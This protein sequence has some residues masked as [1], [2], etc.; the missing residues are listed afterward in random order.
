M[1]KAAAHKREDH[2]GV[3]VEDLNPGEEIE[4]VVLEGGEPIRVR[5][6]EPIPLGHKIAL[7]P[8]QKGEVVREYG[9]PIGRAIRS[10]SAGAHV[11]IH[12]LRSLRWDFGGGG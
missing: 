2:V 3:A 10:I 1:R 6:L 11:H 7:R 12:N 4:V 9:E 5:V 8:I